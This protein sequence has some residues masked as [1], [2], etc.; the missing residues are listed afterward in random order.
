MIAAITRDAENP[1]AVGA[2][3]AIK[4]SHPWGTLGKPEDIARA[5]LFLVSEDAQWV[6][7]HPLVVD[8]GYVAQ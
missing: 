6:T 3:A 5:A 1:I 2:T 7:G 8:G 4:A